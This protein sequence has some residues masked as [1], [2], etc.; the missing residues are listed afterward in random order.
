MYGQCT[1]RPDLVPPVKTVAAGENRT[2]VISTEDRLLYFGEAHYSS[3]SDCEG[4]FCSRSRRSSRSSR[5]SGQS[6]LRGL[7]PGGEADL[8]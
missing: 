3:D 8:A 2:C 5:S 1:T 7:R 4:S 6:P